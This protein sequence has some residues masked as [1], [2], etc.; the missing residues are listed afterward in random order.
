MDNAVFLVTVTVQMYHFTFAFHWFNVFVRLIFNIEH[1]MA[2]MYQEGQ[3]EQACLKLQ[4]KTKILLTLE[5]AKG[6]S[7]VLPQCEFN[8]FHHIVYLI[9]LGK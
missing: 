7:A 8:C 3:Q 5:D 4:K 2:E 6:L 1:I 9:I